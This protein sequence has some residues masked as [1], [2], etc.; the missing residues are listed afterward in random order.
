VLYEGLVRRGYQQEE[1]AQKLRSP[2]GQP[3][4]SRKQDK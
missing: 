2:D 1:F 3:A 4:K